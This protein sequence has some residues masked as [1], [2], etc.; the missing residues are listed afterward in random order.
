M[1]VAQNGYGNAWKPVPEERLDCRMPKK[2]SWGHISEVSAQTLEKVKDF[3]TDLWWC[4]GWEGNGVRVTAA[5]C[6][7]NI[8]TGRLVFLVGLEYAK[9]ARAA[10]VLQLNLD[11]I[12]V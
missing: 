6:D 7:Q 10:H 11:E 3:S 5:R 1:K 8:W 12:A 2:P 9:L 4:F